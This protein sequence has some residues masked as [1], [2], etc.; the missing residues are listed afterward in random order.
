[1]KKEMIKLRSKLV[2]DLWHY[3]SDFIKKEFKL[4]KKDFVLNALDYVDSC[5]ENTDLA[6]MI[7]C[8]VTF[9]E[10]IEKMK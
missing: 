9:N 4:N 2:N 10:V 6:F 7:G 1:M 8:L 5:D 3:H